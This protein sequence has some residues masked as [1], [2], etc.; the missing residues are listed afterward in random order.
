VESSLR[1][2]RESGEEEEGG[3]EE[4]EARRSKLDDAITVVDVELALLPP[5]LLVESLPTFAAEAAAARVL[6]KTRPAASRR[7]RGRALG[8]ERELIV[9]P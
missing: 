3:E 9:F 8:G 7:G 5:P 6:S 1:T 2:S 4:E